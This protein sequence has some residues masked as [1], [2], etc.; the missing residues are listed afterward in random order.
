MNAPPPLVL[1]LCALLVLA[2]GLGLHAH[3]ELPDHHHSA[4]SA[5]L[6]DEHRQAHHDL[7]AEAAADHLAAHLAHGEVDAAAPDKTTGK[8]QPTLTV[9]LLSA[10][11]IL[12]FLRRQPS[13]HFV[14]RCE[15]RPRRRWT[16]FKPLSHAPPL[17][18]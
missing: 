17:A 6:T 2:R 15:H 12:L 10:M 9:A 3:Q 7:I 18:G 4:L 5:Q 1:L 16:H 8:L 11:V 14:V 13:R